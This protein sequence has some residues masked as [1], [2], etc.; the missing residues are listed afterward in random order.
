MD[1]IGNQPSTYRYRDPDKRR[2]YQRDYQRRRR[3]RLKETEDQ[4]CKE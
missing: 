1:L 4:E 2:A 3:A